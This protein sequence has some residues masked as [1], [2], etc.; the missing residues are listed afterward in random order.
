[1][2]QSVSVYICT[3]HQIFRGVC[4]PVKITMEYWNGVRRIDY[5]TE[6]WGILKLKRERKENAKEI[7]EK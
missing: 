3:Y 2:Q 1:M 5:S 6:I 7:E 4:D